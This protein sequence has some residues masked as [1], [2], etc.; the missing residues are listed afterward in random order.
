MTID[1]TIYRDAAGDYRW[2]A[3]A[4]N[5]NVI[6]DG[7]QGYSRK[8]DCSVAMF[9]VMNAAKTGATVSYNDE[10]V[11]FTALSEGVHEDEDGPE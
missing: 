7:G 5:G 9:S 2:H 6:A 8:I 11:D 4:A 1:F 10:P 3:K